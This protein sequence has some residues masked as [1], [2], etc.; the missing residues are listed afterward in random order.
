MYLH[1]GGEKD[2]FTDKIIGIFD[3][4]SVGNIDDIL[5]FKDYIVTDISEGKPKS[6]IL[7]SGMVENEPKVSIYIST[8]SH[9]TL[10]K[11][12]NNIVG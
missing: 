2:I 3:Y 11:R 6:V 4:F 8:V 9:A 1:I 10:V 7:T 5:S 12:L